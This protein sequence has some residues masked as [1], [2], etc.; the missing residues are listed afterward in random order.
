MIL[1]AYWPFLGEGK[2]PT[3][4]PRATAVDGLENMLHHP[5]R[6]IVGLFDQKT[7]VF[8]NFDRLLLGSRNDRETA[9]QKD[10]HD[11]NFSQ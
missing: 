1:P 6:L 11:P 10:C 2:G 9:E 4:L 5:R 3:A 7:V 8:Y